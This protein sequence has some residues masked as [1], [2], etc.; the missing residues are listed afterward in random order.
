MHK[1]KESS[2][3]FLHSPLPNCPF[4][5]DKFSNSPNVPQE[6]NFNFMI[7]ATNIDD[8][9]NTILVKIINKN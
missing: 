8:S 6:V 2:L 5:S 3:K 1:S 9:E 7:V 4:L